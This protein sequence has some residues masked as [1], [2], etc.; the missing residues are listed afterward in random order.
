MNSSFSSDTV[1]LSKAL[2]HVHDQKGGTEKVV[3]GPQQE[4]LMWTGISRVVFM[5]L[6]LETLGRS[7]IWSSENGESILEERVRKTSK[8]VKGED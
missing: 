3:W 5:A 8:S 6:E 4:K 1:L 2:C 7:R